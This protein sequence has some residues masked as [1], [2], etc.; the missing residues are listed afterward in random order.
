M[1]R[2]IAIAMQKGGVGKTTTTINLAAALAQMGQKVLVIDLDPQGNLTEHAGLNPEDIFPTVYTTLK[3]EIESGTGDLKQ[4]VF[5][6]D[7]GFY[8][9]PAQPELSLIDISLINTLSR[10]HVLK[11]LIAP[12]APAFDTIFID[13][14]PSLSLLVINAL[15]AADEVIVPIQTEYLAARGA[16]MVLSTIETIK[17][18]RL[19]SDLKVAGIVLTMADSRTLMTQEVID[20]IR[21]ELG[22][23]YPIFK[24]IIK[25]S[26]RFVESAASGQSLVTYS[27]TSAGAKAYKALAKELI[28]NGA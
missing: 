23:D 20:A 11:N 8:L 12:I 15:V 3:D 25:R 6:T 7:D 26:V 4:A 16:T 21:T 5:E 9:I 22:D 19:N 27:P 28:A 13:C 10:E 24:T 17:R 14:N 1:T 18:K 2:T